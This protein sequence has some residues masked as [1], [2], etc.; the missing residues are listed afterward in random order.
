QDDKL[1]AL[2]R[3]HTA[4]EALKAIDTA[5]SAGFDNFNLDLMFGLP[6]QS[7]NDALSDIDTAIAQNPV[8]I[9]YYQLT[10]EPHTLFAKYPPRLPQDEHIWTL[11]NACQEKLV[12]G[13]F[14]RYEISAYA[15]D[16]F[17]CRHNLN[18]WRF[19]DYLGIGAGAHAKLTDPERNAIH[20]IWKI[21]HP[22]HYREKATSPARI[23][24]RSI[25]RESDKPLEFLM[26]TLRLKEG[27]TPSQ[28]ERRTGMGFAQIV[29]ALE[30]LL[31]DE[32]L[33][34]AG[35]RITCSPEGWNFLD[36]LL[37]RFVS[38]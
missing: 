3:I 14:K 33:K 11:Q 32:L 25:I 24:G 4:R 15:R 30:P 13:G 27:F 9:S 34:R 35:E 8:H 5:R 16:G 1:T 7:L 12:A 26:N 18:Y 10:L 20:R 2:G 6:G 21:R 37:E 29:P 28:F 19:G 36:T 17:Q 23:G 31:V 38:A 22:D